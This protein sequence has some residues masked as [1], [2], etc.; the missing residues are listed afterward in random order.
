MICQAIT[1]ASQP[2]PSPEPSQVEARSD[3]HSDDELNNTDDDDKEPRPMKRKRPSSSCDG[4]MHKK[5]K[6]RLQ[7]R[8]TRRYN[9]FQASWALSQVTLP[10]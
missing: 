10:P 6:H 3:S 8:S 7:Q 2:D 1:T 5:R 4:P 9:T